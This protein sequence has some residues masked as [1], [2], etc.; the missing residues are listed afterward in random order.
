MAIS[1][2]SADASQCIALQY[3]GARDQAPLPADT[4]VK[5]EAT[6]WIDVPLVSS[7]A[8]GQ[9]PHGGF[10]YRP[11]QGDRLHLTYL[12]VADTKPIFTV[13]HL[14]LATSEPCTEGCAKVGEGAGIKL[15]R[16]P[17]AVWPAPVEYTHAP[18][19]NAFLFGDH[20]VVLKVAERRTYCA[21]PPHATDCSAS[22]PC[23]DGSACV[24]P[25]KFCD[26]PPHV[27][28]SDD[29]ACT[30][31]RCV[32]GGVVAMQ[33]PSASVTDKSTYRYWSARERAF[34]PLDGREPDA[35]HVDAHL[36]NSVS[37]MW[38]EYAERWIMLSNHELDTY[39]GQR[40]VALRSSKEL[41]GPWSA[42]ET[43]MENLGGQR[44]YNPRF[45]PA[46]TRAHRVYWT[47]TYDAYDASWPMHGQPFD[48][49]VFLYETDLAATDPIARS[50]VATS[51][52]STSSA[53]RSRSH[54]NAD[55]SSSG[56]TGT[57]RSSSPSENAR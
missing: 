41:L 37:I 48:Y 56:E 44:S 11:D 18:E 8:P 15:E 46:Y 13:T 26:S 3:L 33:I 4:H 53:T 7:S 34:T 39:S 5:D 31:G 50:R 17:A 12:S 51:G 35:I 49:N 36:G 9:R 25:G 52:G 32:A 43:I 10:A 23:S 14:G 24:T 29:A 42:P 38:S 6:V 54:E 30:S 55:A 21:A 20:Y 1:D 16:E 47:A 45:V 19:Q 40:L 57:A 22:R 28:C 2:P 27:A